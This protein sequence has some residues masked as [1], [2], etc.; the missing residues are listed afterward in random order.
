[1]KGSSTLTFIFIL[2]LLL[3]GML[4]YIAHFPEARPLK[5]DEGRYQMKALQIAS[6]EYPPQDFIWPPLYQFLVGGMYALFGIRR[7]PV[8]LFQIIL[9]FV[10]GYIFYRLILF[11]GLGE[12]PAA[13]GLFLFMM[14][15]QIA[16]F[17]QYLWPEIVHLFFVFLML[18]LLFLTPRGKAL[19]L[20]G[21]G[22]CLGA[23]I[24]TKSLLTPFSPV[25]IVAAAVRAADS[26]FRS[27]LRAALLFV[28]G[29]FLVV[30][31]LVFYNGVR[32][33]FWGVADAMAFNL[34]LGW[35]GDVSAAEKFDEYQKYS[36][37]PTERSRIVRERVLR[38]MGEEGLGNVIRT[39]VKR[40]YFRLFNKDSFLMEQF[41]GNRWSSKKVNSGSWMVDALTYWSY[42]IYVTT[43]FLGAVGVFQIRWRDDLARCILSG[44]FIVYNLGLFLFFFVKTR[45]RIPIMPAIIFFAAL[46]IYYFH[47][48][49][50]EL[51]GLPKPGLRFAVGCVAAAMFLFLAFFP[52]PV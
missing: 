18:G 50:N 19:A 38:K 13:V 49:Q 23:A 34:W 6:G 8:E 43:L 5:G 21:S 24:L 33:R 35:K 27:R 44:L 30:M 31:P 2:A 7:L 17:C 16:S 11:S 45:Y 47:K 3:Q 51:G 48:E 9:F 12:A 25:L 29:L 4:L 22:I 32:Y 37:L 46:G 26:T 1:M 14:D 42:V 28:L 39:Q 40:Q 20:I 36:D 41:P 15:P 10:S 52:E